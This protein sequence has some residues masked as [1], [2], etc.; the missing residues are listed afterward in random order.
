MAFYSLNTSTPIMIDL[1]SSSPGKNN[2]ISSASMPQPPKR[3][4]IIINLDIPRLSFEIDGNEDD[5]IP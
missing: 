5:V 2:A 3:A 4:K 1:D